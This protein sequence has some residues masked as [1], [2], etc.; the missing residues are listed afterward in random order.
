MFGVSGSHLIILAIILIFLGPKKLP[1]LAQ[2]MGKA[3]RNFKDAMSGVEE[4]R[5]RHVEE[6]HKIQPPPVISTADPH[7]PIP[8]K[9]GQ[10][11]PSKKS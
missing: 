7:A 11:D 2:T 6:N 10:D 1:A 4:A 9:D 3:L 8:P 5:F